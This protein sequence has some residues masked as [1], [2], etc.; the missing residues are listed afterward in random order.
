[1]IDNINK[2]HEIFLHIVKTSRLE[3]ELTIM[4]IVSKYRSPVH[5]LLCN[6]THTAKV[7]YSEHTF[8][9]KSICESID[10]VRG[11][12]PIHRIVGNKY[13][14]KISINGILNAIKCLLYRYYRVEHI[15]CNGH[16][17]QC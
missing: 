1:M 10:I 3:L 4:D 8:S 17:I 15:V 6:W 11:R 7:R 16:T 2:L 13:I 12:I 5:F 9:I 14:R